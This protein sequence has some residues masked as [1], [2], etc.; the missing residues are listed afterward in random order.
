MVK[1][2][3]NVD[4]KKAISDKNESETQDTTEKEKGDMTASI[5]T[6]EGEDKSKS[7]SSKEGSKKNKVDEEK[8]K[9]K[10]IEL[11]MKKWE[12]EQVDFLFISIN[13]LKANES[14]DGAWARRA[15][16]SA[17]ASAT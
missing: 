5:E 6:K 13:R 17:T 16:G 9:R 4:E 12:R 2:I 8:N 14:H 15:R 10:Q 3:E 11:E 1:E 7:K